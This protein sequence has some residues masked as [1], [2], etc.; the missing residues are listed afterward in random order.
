M[1]TDWLIIPFIIIL[2]LITYVKYK[3]AGYI[4]RILLSTI[5]NVIASNLY[6]ENKKSIPNSAN[7]LYFIFIFSVIIFIY[8][9]SQRFYPN[10]VE[11]FSW[12]IPIISFF[13]LLFIIIS[14]QIINIISEKVFM[15][16]EIGEE[17]N[18]NINFFNQSA[19][20]F[21]FPIT[22][23]ISFSNFPEIFIFLGFA[24]ILIL[25]ILKI[26][27][28]LKI[29]FSKQLNILYMFLYLCTVEIIPILYFVKF[30]TL[31]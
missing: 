17:Y 22:V 30:S 20:I 1:N 21:L 6:K 15:I 16:N 28:L 29:N 24:V 8:Q 5:N 13:F 7:I 14:N 31:I 10:I 27:R 19:G 4:R 11:K 12:L 18:H 25:Y 23:L 9:V 3:Y 2:A 26:F